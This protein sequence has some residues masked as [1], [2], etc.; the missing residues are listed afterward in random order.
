MKAYILD[1]GIIIDDNDKFSFIQYY[2]ARKLFSIIKKLSC[3]YYIDCEIF[4]LDKKSNKKIR[5]WKNKYSTIKQYPIQ[6]SY[7]ILSLLKKL[8]KKYD[9]YL[10]AIGD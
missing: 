7:T 5:Y 2:E 4:D 1:F 3:I 8:P 9:K 6:D 10:Y